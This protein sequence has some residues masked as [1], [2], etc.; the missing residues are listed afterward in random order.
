MKKFFSMLFIVFT[1]TSFCQ[2]G[3]KIDD[4]KLTD[5]ATPTSP[6]FILADKA[7]ASINKP[8]NP[9]ALAINLLNLWE[10]GGIEVTPY[11]LTPKPRLTFD[12]YLDKKMPI[13]QTL[14]FSVSSF[15]TDTSSNVSAGFKVHLFR[16][17]SKKAK[18]PIRDKVAE[19]IDL[20]ANDPDQLDTVAIKKK[21]SELRELFDV[22]K[23]KGIFIAEIA[24]AI[25]GTSSSNTYKNLSS[26]KSGVWANIRWSP[27]FKSNT[28]D[29]APSFSL[30][31]LARY[32]WASNASAKIG[33]DS[34][35]FDYGLSLNFQ[36]SRF[37]LSLEYV[38][39]RDISI[40]KNYDRFAFI[41]NYMVN[42]NIYIVSS[43]G[44]NFD[45]V[46]DIIALFGVKFAISRE[47]LVYK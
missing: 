32:S 34:S 46:E 15:K 24:G 10:G 20:L 3:S 4:L 43:F 39:R 13:L 44:K 25:I 16:L 18:V 30:I 22:N 2:S 33:S 21:N 27:Y 7:P 19:I 29:N 9:K 31:G 36:K 40:K 26:S 14:N 37:D 47:K 23:A 42:E 41:A 6:G 28:D 12:N 8:T 17:F 38:N 11:W 1:T 5:L 35:F 45:N